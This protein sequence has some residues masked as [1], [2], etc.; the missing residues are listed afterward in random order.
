MQNIMRTIPCVAICFLTGCLARPH[1]DKQ[2]FVFA[3]P[4]IGTPKIDAG[5]HILGFRTLQV[6]EPFAGRS[7]VY[8]T[9]EFSYDRDPY[10]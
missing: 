3:P 2:T 9:G 6:A 10:A 8:R 7:F 1:L 4:S 5:S